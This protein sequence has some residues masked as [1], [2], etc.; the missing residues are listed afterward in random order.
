MAPASSP[1]QLFL[2]LISLGAYSYAFY[3]MLTEPSML[4]IRKLIP[5]VLHKYGLFKFL[6]NQCLL[7][8]F[9]NSLLH[10]GAHFFAFLRRPRDLFFTCL[11]YPVG[12]I[13]VYSFWA[14]W[15]LMGREMI[16]PREVS[17]WYPDWLNHVAHTIPA[18]VNIL[19]ALSIHHRYS[20]NGVALTLAYLLCYLT[21]LLHMKQESGVF[22]Y[23]YL[24]AMNQTQFMIYV[25]S[26][27][28]FIYL[29]YKSGQLLTSLAHAKPTQRPT[30][31]EKR[32]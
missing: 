1:V 20:K 9:I 28:V 17:E 8:Q 3:W 21:F 4:N 14:V 26:T 31:K 7:M 12:S 22:I 15:H 6:T 29:M 13:V 19:L 16:F 11:A 10:V 5:P 25:A 27:A 2:G 24:D 30:L 32:K 23:K 18:A